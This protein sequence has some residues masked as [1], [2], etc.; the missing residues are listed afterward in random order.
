MQLTDSTSLPLH[1]SLSAASAAVFLVLASCFCLCVLALCQI[2]RHVDQQTGVICVAQTLGAAIKMCCFTAAAGAVMSVRL[3]NSPCLILLD[4]DMSDQPGL[5]A[6]SSDAQY[7]ARQSAT[8]STLSSCVLL[9]EHLALAA[10]GCI[11]KCNTQL[12]VHI[13]SHLQLVLYCSQ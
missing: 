5:P 7:T 11:S 6:S 1:V 9:G 12:V 4:G 10:F 2:S 3:S 13:P 8:H